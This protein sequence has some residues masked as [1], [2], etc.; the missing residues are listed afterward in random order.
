MELSPE[1]RVKLS[2]ECTERLWEEVDRR[3]GIKEVSKSLGY[4]RSKIYNWKNKNSF[5]PTDFVIEILGN[6]LDDEI[7][8]LKGKSRSNPIRNPRLPLD[9]SDELLCRIEFSVSTNE[10]GTP[11]YITD[12]LG[13]L[14]RFHTLLD[15][16]GKV[17]YQ[18]YTRDSCFQL[19]FPCYLHTLF[20]E[21][22]HGMD[23]TALVDEKGNVEDGEIYVEGER[24]AE[25]NYPNEIYNRNKKLELALSKEKGD[26]VREILGKEAKRAERTLES[27][28]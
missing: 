17:P 8:A 7:K 4:S 18:I 12:D 26:V 11:M 20:R 27:V 25:E 2:D 22:S 13:N 28:T 23:K 5:L 6:C 19:N 9:P 21:T 15:E 10:N 3:G 1:I 24:I 14:R 16:I